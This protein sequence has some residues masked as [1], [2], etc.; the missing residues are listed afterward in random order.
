MNYVFPLAFAL[1]TFSITA[2]MVILGITGNA[3]LAADVG[4]IHAALTALF[5]S[6]SAN[7]RSLILNPSSDCSAD[8]VLRGRLLLMAPLAAASYVLSVL[9]SEIDSWLVVALILRRC[10][11]WISEVHLSEKE[12]T[13]DKAFARNF[14]YFQAAAFLVA[15]AGLISGFSHPFLGL[16]IWALSPLAMS[17]QFVRDRLKTSSVSD[18]SW[19]LMAP[20]LGSTMVIG[21][22]LYVFRLIIVLIAGKET[23]G[24]LF[25]A[26]ALGGI[27]GSVFSQVL[28]PSVVLYE[29]RSNRSFFSPRVNAILTSVLLAGFLVFML[30]LHPP[31]MLAFLNLNRYFWGALGA[32]LVG[33]VIMVFAQHK[34]FQLLQRPGNNNLFGP[35]LLMNLLIVACVPYFYFILGKDALMILYLISSVLAYVLY[36]SSERRL[37]DERAAS[38]RRFYNYGIAVL[39]LIPV[40]LSAEAGLFRSSAMVYDSGGVLTRLPVPLSVLACLVGI[41][42]LG[43]Y[44]RANV[45]LAYIFS[46]FVLM[47]IASMVSTGGNGSDAQAKMLLL[48]QFTLPMTALVLGQLFAHESD[49]QVVV[50]N[51]FL[52]VLWLVVPL[53]LLSTIMDGTFYL[54]PKI[55][56]FSI[57]QHLQYVPVIFV[58]AY[59]VSTYCQIEKNK[60]SIL[61]LM[62]IPIIGIYTVWSQSMSA[63]ILYSIG[64]LGLVFIHHR[65]KINK[66]LILSVITAFLASGSF[67]FFTKNLNGGLYWSRNTD[68]RTMEERHG[69]PANGLTNQAKRH[70]SIVDKVNVSSRIDYWKYHLEKSTIS[71]KGF[72]F[73]IPDRPDRQEFESVH[74]YYID[75]LY[76]YGLISL[77]PILVL[78][79]YTFA[80]LYR[81]RS[82]VLSSPDIMILSLTVMYLIIIDNSIKVGLRQPYP[83][84]FTFFV[85][86]MLTAKLMIMSSEKDKTRAEFLPVKHARLS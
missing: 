22:S 56:I 33:G 74:N 20:Q 50:K 6:F 19:H 48:L 49:V 61:T 4:I 11:E 46:S 27:V 5:F 82:R 60:V 32:S 10:V 72:L 1:N 73:G 39:I 23:A 29:D 84:I 24:I 9:P 7:A 35:D 53:Q 31:D 28:G 15:I 30:S 67:L 43:R 2:L 42:L 16:Y 37:D 76:N 59:L 52:L 58:S 47:L 81:H 25:T 78:I 3:R 70:L 71:A 36:W 34:R 45:S 62:L 83:G 18:S 17:F 44:E 79:A 13:D 63:I 51:A 65:G 38:V 54:A 68:V 8:L 85:W 26:F 75:L 40:F 57:Y 12:W 80:L 14:L 66:L 55:W 86:G 69:M 21:I 64:T 41:P 77:I